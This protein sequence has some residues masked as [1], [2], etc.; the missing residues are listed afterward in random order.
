MALRLWDRTEIRKMCRPSDQEPC[1]PSIGGL[2]V[3]SIG[4][5]LMT[6]LRMVFPRLEGS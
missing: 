3:P 4:S 6:P 2:P 1:R 5:L